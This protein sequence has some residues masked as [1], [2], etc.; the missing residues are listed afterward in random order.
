MASFESD[1]RR[2]RF[3]A[4]MRHKK[5]KMRNRFPRLKKSDQRRLERLAMGV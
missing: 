3:V 5:A 4:A 1:K 2:K